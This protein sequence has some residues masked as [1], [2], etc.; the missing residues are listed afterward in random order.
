MDCNWR[1]DIDGNIDIYIDLMIWIHV[2]VVVN[3][4]FDDDSNPSIDGLLS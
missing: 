1:L 4:D 3:G 2:I